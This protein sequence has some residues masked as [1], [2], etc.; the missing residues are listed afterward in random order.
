MAEFAKAGDA[1]GMAA[2]IKVVGAACG[3]CHKTYRER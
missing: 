3:A 1:D 2:Q